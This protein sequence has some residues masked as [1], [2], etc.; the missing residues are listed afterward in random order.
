MGK[1]SLPKDRRLLYPFLLTLGILIL[2]Q[3][4]KL[5]IVQNIP[6]NSIGF[7]VIGDFLRIIHVRNTG[8]AFSLGYEL[9][10]PVRM[11]LFSFVPLGVLI[12]LIGYYFRTAEFTLFQ[13]WTIAG[14]I[15]GGF[16][17][18]IDRMFRPE[19]VVDFID[20]K[21][22]GLFGMERFPTF[23]VADS[24][25]VVA[26]ILLFISLSFMPQGTGVVDTPPPDPKEPS[27]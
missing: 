16:G 23:N 25:V 18:I 11:V 14:I 24:S 8:V 19:G 3:W 13:R 7:R 2:D 1:P 15:G 5:W 17:N 9:S 4:T 22:Y 6:M 26:G 27:V 21:F 10:A 12:A 20:V